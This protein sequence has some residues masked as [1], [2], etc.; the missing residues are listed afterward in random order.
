M[1]LNE[2]AFAAKAAPEF[3]LFTLGTIDGRF[4]PLEDARVLRTLLADYTLAGAEGPFLLL[5]HTAS[6][7]PRRT[8]L[9]EGSFRAGEPIGVAEYGDV[10]LWLE[11]SLAPS[12]AGRLRQALYKPPEVYL[13]V[14]ALG[15]RQGFMFRA[16]VPML[17]AGFLASP[18]ALQNQDVAD[19]YTGRALHRPGGYAIRFQPGTDAM[20]QDLMRYRLFRVE[21]KLGRNSKAAEMNTPA[22]PAPPGS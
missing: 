11:I 5:K 22:S 8:L 16:P 7:A 12:L 4:P 15:S 9:R 17:A 1:E 6:S 3:V 10:D 14:W 18:V 13:I 19:L 2:R 20:W 21:D